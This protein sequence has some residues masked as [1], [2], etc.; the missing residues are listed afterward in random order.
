MWTSVLEVNDAPF[1][2]QSV[3]P[4]QVRHAAVVGWTASASLTVPSSLKAAAL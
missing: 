4:W 1:F 2:F 3:S